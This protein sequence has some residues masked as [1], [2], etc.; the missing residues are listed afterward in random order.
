MIGIDTAP[1]IY[2]FEENPRFF[3]LVQALVAWVDEDD[4]RRLV[5]SPITLAEI[6]VYP[7][8]ENQQALI[9]TYRSALLDSATIAVHQIGISDYVR[10]AELRAKYNI[11]T[12][13]ALQ[14]AG[15]LSAACDVF[16]SQ[17]IYSCVV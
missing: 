6:F 11:H 16:L 2:Y 8:R 9:E 13:D 15:C 1:I 17:M 12:A 4:Q 14:I 7:I 5:T 10:A 3:S